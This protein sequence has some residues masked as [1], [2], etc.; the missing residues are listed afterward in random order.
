MELIFEHLDEVVYALIAVISAAIG[1]IANQ[2]KNP[3]VKKLFSKNSAYLSLRRSSEIG[4][5][6]ELMRVSSEAN[7]KTDW[8]KHLIVFRIYKNGVDKLRTEIHIKNN[9]LVDRNTCFLDNIP[10]AY[11]NSFFDSVEKDGQVDVENVSED[12]D[13]KN[14]SSLMSTNEVNSYIV[15]KLGQKMYLLIASEEWR[16]Y[17]NEIIKI[18]EEVMRLHESINMIYDYRIN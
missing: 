18:R 5:V 6:T 4:I 8:L 9:V 12:K 14:F 16:A 3:E 1:F 2:L 7:K 13:F 11:Y 15:I 17:G 10:S